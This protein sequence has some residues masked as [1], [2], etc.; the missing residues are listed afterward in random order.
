MRLF[1]THGICLWLQLP[2][3]ILKTYADSKGISK[4]DLYYVEGK[5]KVAYFPD[6]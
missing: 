5:R 6:E 4:G 2:D 3:F 1:L